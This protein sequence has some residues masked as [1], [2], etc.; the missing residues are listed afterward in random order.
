MAY[1]YSV[2]IR[3][4]G[5][6]KWRVISGTDESIV[7][8]KAQAQIR[9][10]DFQY[11]TKLDKERR[12]SDRESQR[13]EEAEKRQE[14]AERTQEAQQEIEAVK[15]IL[16]AT[17]E[18]N[19]AIDWEQLK[20]RKPFPAK[21]PSPPN[22]KEFP[23]EPQK[24][25]PHFQPVLTILD[26]MIKSRAERKQLEAQTLFEQAYAYWTQKVEEVKTENDQRY[27][28]HVTLLEK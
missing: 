1:R 2:E 20:D 24:D 19:D 3:H 10:W 11:Q 17:L 4:E 26:K 7:R 13:M 23:Q 5:L 22:Y 8:A 28:E 9:Q 6:G 14:A 18:V 16:R 15:A 21:E 12:L 27:N 25:A